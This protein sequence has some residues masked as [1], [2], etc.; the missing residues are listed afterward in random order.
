[1]SA[2]L[3]KRRLSA[4][5]AVKPLSSA[6]ARLCM[7]LQPEWHTERFR[8]LAKGVF[9]DPNDWRKSDTIY[10][11]SRPDLD[12]Y[13]AE[14]PDASFQIVTQAEYKAIMEKFESEC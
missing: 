10:Y 14:Q 6:P 11:T 8:A 9:D 7:P 13:V 2:A 12:M 1:M 4:L 3:M 5:E